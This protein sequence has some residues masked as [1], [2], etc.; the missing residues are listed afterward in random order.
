M[1]TGNF[2]TINANKIYAI[3]N[4]DKFDMLTE[5]ASSFGYDEEEK[6]CDRNRSYPAKIFATKSIYTTLINSDYTAYDI[7]SNLIVRAGY[8]EHQ[9]LDYD[10][11]VKMDALY[12]NE[13]ELSDFNGNTNEMAETIISDLGDEIKYWGEC[14]GFNVGLFTMLRKKMIAKLTDILNKEVNRLEQDC[15]RFCDQPLGVFARF[16]NGETIYTP[17]QKNENETITIPVNAL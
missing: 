10:I 14:G 11:C 8:Y 3:T 17:I 7:T 12:P 5:I 4:E 16:S 6:Y 15:E 9:N 13:Y 1:A 2:S